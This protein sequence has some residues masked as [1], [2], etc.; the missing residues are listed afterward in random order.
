VGRRAG[1]GTGGK[2]GS[3]RS[4]S[5]RRRADTIEGAAPRPA[6]SANPKPR[7]TR[8][9]RGKT[10]GDPSGPVAR[11]NGRFPVVAV[12]ASAGGLDAMTELLRNLPDDPGAA[13]VLLQHLHAERVSL[14]PEILQKASRLPVRAITAGLRL[15]PNVVYVA[16]S[17]HDVRLSGGV[18]SLVPKPAIRGREMP[19]DRLF[20]SVADQYD[21]CSVGVVLSGTLSDGALGLRAIKDAGGVTFAQDPATAS[22]SEMPRAAVI[23]GGVDRVLAPERIAREIVRF[24][25]HPYLRVESE[26]AGEENE[27]TRK[28]DHETEAGAG[29]R[30]IQILRS[31]TG[32]DFSSY[33]QS[34]FR[35]R[36]HRRMALR[37]VT[38]LGKYVEFLRSNPQEIDALYDDILITVT[39]FFRDPGVFEAL[40]TKAFPAIIA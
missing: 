30:L 38:T 28:A 33:R 16:P 32:V 5:R 4:R 24:T 8:T 22:F 37:R 34:T 9:R 14:L 12:G 10:E 11:G 20:E 29:R 31:A 39:R 26:P 35:R 7:R 13:V 2:A 40:R 15:Q 19:I 6:N 36:V 23:A 17:S 3:T 25:K 18:F 27:K 21:V 1:S